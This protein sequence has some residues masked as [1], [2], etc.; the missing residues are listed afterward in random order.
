MTEANWDL[1]R[2]FF[3]VT[4][5]GSVNRAARELG[6]SQPT[7]SRRLKELERHVGA[8]LFF[9]ISTGVKLTQ[10]GEELRRSAGEMVQSFD[11]FNRNLSARVSDRSSAVKISATEGLTKHWLLPRVS[12]LRAQHSQLRLEITSTISKQNL[13][14]SD[15]DFVLRMGDPGDDELVGR[16]VAAVQFGLFGSANYLSKRPPPRT[17]EE[18]SDHELVSSPTDFVE[19]QG[20]RAGRM[21]LLTHFKKAVEAGNGLRLMPLANHF[22]AVAQGLGIAF[23][24]VPFALSESLVRVLPQEASSMDLWLLRRRETDLRK[25]TRRVWRFLESE[26]SQSRPWFLGLAETRKL[27]QQVA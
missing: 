13:A 22:A 4:K 26:L 25:M 14:A 5:M 6:I 7:L 16:R 19:L 23:L 2:L 10:E 12:K 9:R 8:P 24:A 20:E 18:L 1:F 17:L 11:S 21:M 15:L 27:L 3:T